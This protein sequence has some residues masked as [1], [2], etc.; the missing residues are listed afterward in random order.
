MRTERESRLATVTVER[1]RLCGRRRR[2]PG[3][4]VQLAESR[5]FQ[6]IYYGEGDVRHAVIV[7]PGE[8]VCWHHG[9]DY[10]V[11]ARREA[12]R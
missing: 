1:C 11:L 7:Q 3:G 4:G 9:A 8:V 5:E 2:V 6:V 12:R 10:P